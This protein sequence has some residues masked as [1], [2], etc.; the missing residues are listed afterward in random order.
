MARGMITHVELPADDLDRAKRFYAAVAGWDASEMGGMPGYLVFRTEEGHGGGIGKRGDT[1]GRTLR[2]YIDVDKLEEAV[3]AAEANGGVSVEPPAD[4]P[5]M[6]RF[7][8]VRDPEGTE[9]GLWEP[10]PSA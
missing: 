10:T 6:G 9:V 7:A 5:G 8:V 4:V 2:I 1:V 3:A